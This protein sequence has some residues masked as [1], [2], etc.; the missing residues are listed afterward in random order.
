MVKAKRSDPWIWYN[1]VAGALRGS[2]W[3]PSY[4]GSSR[5]SVLFCLMVLLCCRSSITDTG[6]EIGQLL[7][8]QSLTYLLAALLPDWKNCPLAEH[9]IGRIHDQQ[10]P[11]AWSANLDTSSPNYHYVYLSLL[12]ADRLPQMIQT[13]DYALEYS[14]WS[15]RHCLLRAKVTWWTR[16]LWREYC[17]LVQWQCLALA[18]SL[19]TLLALWYLMAVCL[20]LLLSAQLRNIVCLQ[21][22][23]NVA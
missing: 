6:T 22:L 10:I 11:W 23:Y 2:L 21:L 13:F 5:P 15:F 4:P 9:L 3:S 16:F 19:L 14:R 7:H 1:C 12:Q 17:G 8:C 18:V 20:Y